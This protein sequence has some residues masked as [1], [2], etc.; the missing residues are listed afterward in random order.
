[1]KVFITWHQDT[2]GRSCHKLREI[3]TLFLYKQ[4]ISSKRVV[5]CKHDSWYAK[6]QRILNHTILDKT[7]T[8][9]PKCSKTLSINGFT[10][11]THWDG[12]SYQEFIANLDKINKFIYQCSRSGFKSCSVTFS[13]R[14]S[15]DPSRLYEWVQAGHLKSKVLQSY[16]LDIKKF[17]YSF[18]PEGLTAYPIV[19]HIRRGDIAHQLT[20]KNKHCA[21]SVYLPVIKKLQ[22]MH[23]KPIF[24]LTEIQ[25]SED[26]RL[27]ES[28][29]KAAGLKSIRFIYGER[30]DTCFHFF[31]MVS[32][33]ILVVSPS[34]QFSLFASYLLDPDSTVVK[35]LP[36]A[37]YKGSFIND[38]IITL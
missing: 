12:L 19:I 10:E 9:L 15:V 20:R 27:L 26:V 14:G 31:M 8:Y 6:N 17:I 33:N 1:V 30:Q 21:T 25:N 2:G 38:N 5:I 11:P 34:S 28:N 23:S 4:L 32:A 18:K 22:S 13:S 35:C 3:L 24:V 29:C 7:F 36:D 37:A 16:I